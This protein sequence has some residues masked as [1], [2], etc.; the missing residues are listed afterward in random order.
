MVKIKAPLFIGALS[1][2]C[3]FTPISAQET[4]NKNT[5]KNLILIPLT[6]QSTDSTCGVAAVQSILAYYGDEIREDNLA[7]AL[8]SDP[9][10]GTDYKR[11]LEYAKSKG[12]EATAYTDMTLKQLQEFI[13]KGQPVICA[14][15]AWSDKPASYSEDWDD[16]HYA[17]VVGYD[18]DRIYF[19]DPSTLGNYTYIPTAEFLKRWHD[20][21]QRGEKL[22]HFGMVITKNKPVYNPEAVKYLE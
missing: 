9:K 18:N 17:I 10:T 22:I 20:I 6:R 13:S 15:Q 4:F 3:L 5:I 21:D 11:V 19:M 12:Y 1:A 14:L 8:G 16:G 7:K 2:I